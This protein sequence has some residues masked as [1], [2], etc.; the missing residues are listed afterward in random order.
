[1]FE[2]A[3]RCVG[4]LL[5]GVVHSVEFSAGQRQSEQIIVYV[6]SMTSGLGCDGDTIAATLV[7]GR[8]VG[9]TRLSRGCGSEVEEGGHPKVR[10]T[11][12]R[13]RFHVSV[14]QRVPQLSRSTKVWLAKAEKFRTELVSKT[15]SRGFESS[16]PRL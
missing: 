1:M 8:G 15:R 10:G 11:R 12:S 3:G 9:A 7:C 13:P 2:E 4:L 5:L 16:L 14:P 6:I